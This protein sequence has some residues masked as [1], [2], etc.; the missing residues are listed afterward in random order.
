MKPQSRSVVNKHK[1]GFD[2]EIMALQ[3]SDSITKH[4]LHSRLDISYKL[5]NLLKTLRLIVMTT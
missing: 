1:Q 3:F 4:F 5:Q 2:H